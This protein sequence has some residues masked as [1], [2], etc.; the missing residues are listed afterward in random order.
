MG[1]I[2]FGLLLLLRENLRAPAFMAHEDPLPSKPLSL[3]PVFLAMFMDI[4]AWQ[5]NASLSFA[6]HMGA[7]YIWRTAHLVHSSFRGRVL[8]FFVVELVM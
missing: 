6:A 7:S 5:L 2:A 3:G 1:F 8:Y 4:F